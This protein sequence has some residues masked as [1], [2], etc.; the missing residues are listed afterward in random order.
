M[1]PEDGRHA[2]TTARGSYR[3]PSSRA[4]RPLRPQNARERRC[5]RQGRRALAAPERV[6][7]CYDPL[8][9]NSTVRSLAAGAALCLAVGCAGPTALD[10]CNANC[11][12]DKKCGSSSD[13][14]LEICRE[15]CSALTTGL[16]ESCANA[17]QVFQAQLDC[18]NHPDAC[19]FN[20]RVDCQN[21]AAESLCMPRSS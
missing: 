8:M 7:L 2:S 11:D 14:A 1:L 21:G 17:A 15:T 10:V 9:F 18:L 5:A 4:L 12:N 19:D 20:A 13:D 3:R 6:P 16:K